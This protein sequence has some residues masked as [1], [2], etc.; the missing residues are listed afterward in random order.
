LKRRFPSWTFQRIWALVRSTQGDRVVVRAG[1][2]RVEVAKDSPAEEASARERETGEKERE[3]R[4]LEEKMLVM[5]PAASETTSAAIEAPSAVAAKAEDRRQSHDGKGAGF[6]A[7]RS[8][9]AP[10]A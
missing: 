2:I 1:A 4:G 3:S 7:F 10:K 9:M 8:G 5:A 6:A